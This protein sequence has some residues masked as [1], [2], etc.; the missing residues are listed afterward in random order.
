[1]NEEKWYVL[2]TSP[3]AEKKV[4]DR[5]LE[6]GVNVYLPIIEEV[7]QWSDRKK[8]VKKALF[9]GYLFIKST[10]PNLWKCLTDPGA[11]KFI[12]FSDDYATVSEEDISSI[13]RIVETGMAIE[14]MV[15]NIST[16]EKVKIIGGPL[17][18]MVGECVQKEN[19]DYFIVNI[20]GIKRQLVVSI[21]RKFLKVIEG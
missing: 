5:L 15:S 13:K 4:A 1:M 12:S 17:E 10:K 3:R 11:L 7:R 20:S 6:N 9:D 16:G 21:P 19:Q 18:G 2:Y 14:P 8:K